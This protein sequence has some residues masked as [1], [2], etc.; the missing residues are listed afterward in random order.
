M[1]RAFKLTVTAAVTLQPRPSRAS[2]VELCRAHRPSR[3]R[4]RASESS[5]R[6]PNP[7]RDLSVTVLQA[8]VQFDGFDGDRRQSRFRAAFEHFGLVLGLR[9]L[10]LSAVRECRL[11]ARKKGPDGALAM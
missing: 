2:S 11:A 5:L 10:H 7:G 8:P 6:P 9:S 4:H 1:G 3:V